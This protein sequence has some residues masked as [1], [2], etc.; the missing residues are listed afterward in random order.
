MNLAGRLTE[1]S[2]GVGALLLASGTLLCCALPILLVTLGMGATVAAWVITAPWLVTLSHYKG[3]M[4]ALSGA[5]LLAAGSLLYRP[6][7]MCPTDARLAR[8]CAVADRWNRRV[9]GLAG[10]LWVIGAF[11]AYL[12]LPLRQWLGL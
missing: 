2:A 9:L 8:L 7:R 1:A 5:G 12:L 3:W 4:F 6:G 10:A 11:A